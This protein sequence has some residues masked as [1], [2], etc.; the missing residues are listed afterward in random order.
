LQAIGY[1]RCA[2][3]ISLIQEG[4]LL[5]AA[6]SLV[7]GVIA[8]T[9]LNG[10]AVRFTMG[11]FTLRIDGVAILIGCSVGLLLGV[12]GALPPALKALRAEVAASLKAV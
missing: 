11:A 8:L 2:I 10:M 7:S 3:L 9:V 4:V 12:V 5:S 6:G 1:R